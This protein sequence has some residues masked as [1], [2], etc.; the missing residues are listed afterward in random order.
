MKRGEGKGARR[1][2][3]VLARK[4]GGSVYRMSD[5]MRVYCTSTWTNWSKIVLLSYAF[6]Q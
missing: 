1:C 3:A 2:D 5:T 6:I 4:V